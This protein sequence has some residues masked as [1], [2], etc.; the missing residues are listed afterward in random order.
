MRN[1]GGRDPTWGNGARETGRL[2]PLNAAKAERAKTVPLALVQHAFKPGQSGNPGGRTT[3]FAECQRLAREA[4]PDAMRRL[5]ELMASPD[6]RVALM[7]A[8][9]VLERAWGKPREYDPD[10]SVKRYSE[11]SPEAREREIARLIAEGRTV[12]EQAKLMEQPA[13]RHVGAGRNPRIKPTP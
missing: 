8:D 10:S 12:I 3:S 1:Q 13:R 7:A 6:E 11:M 5:I 2:H 9:K 4:S